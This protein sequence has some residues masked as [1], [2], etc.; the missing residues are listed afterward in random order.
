LPASA[1]GIQTAQ[2]NKLLFFVCVIVIKI[3]Y[4]RNSNAKTSHPA[5]TVAGMSR[6]CLKDYETFNST[7]ILYSSEY[8]HDYHNVSKLCNNTTNYFGCVDISVRIVNRLWAG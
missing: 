4:L 2:K 8:H 7:M 5:E 3:K 6:K 1:T